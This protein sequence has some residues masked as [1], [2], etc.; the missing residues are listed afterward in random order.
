[1]SETLLPSVK[2]H[3]PVVVVSDTHLG[4]RNGAAELLSEFLDHMTCDRLILNGDIIDGLRLSARRPRPFTEAQARAIDSIN[5]KV[6]EGVDVVYIPGNHDARLRGLARAGEKSHQKFMGIQFENSLEMTDAHGRKLLFTHGDRLGAMPGIAKGLPKWLDAAI[7]DYTY[8]ALTRASALID[9]LG[10]LTLRRHFGL[11]AKTRRAIETRNGDKIAR[12]DMAI[13]YAHEHGYDGIVCGH[14]HAFEK[15]TSKE[16]VLY[17]NSGDWVENY[18]ALV[19]DKGGDWRV[20]DWGRE[21]TLRGLSR[22]FNLR[23]APN[24]N[25]QY[26][27]ATHKMLAEIDRIWPGKQKKSKTVKYQ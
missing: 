18:T 16:G 4:M 20:L 27:P 9:K 23:A 1:M 5:R 2:P 10:H 13:R 19:F 24:P 17:L 15:R 6:A 8:V 25:A 14:F 11:A 7:Y 22:A 3:Y 21:R 26:R 12:E